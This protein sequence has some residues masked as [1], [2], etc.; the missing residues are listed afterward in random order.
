MKSDEV[1]RDRPEIDAQQI[2]ETRKLHCV[3]NT[4]EP[5]LIKFRKLSCYCAQCLQGFSEDCLKSVYVPPYQ[6]KKI[7]LVKSKADTGNS[8]EKEN[9]E[10][11]KK[12]TEET[13]KST[14][15]AKRNTEGAKKNTEGAKGNTEETKKSK[16]VKKREP[17]I[18]TENE[19]NR[20]RPLVFTSLYGEEENQIQKQISGEEVYSS[21]IACKSYKDLEMFAGQVQ[22]SPI[23]ENPPEVTLL[24]HKRTVD[25]ASLSILP[26]DDDLTNLFPCLIY[27]DDKS[28]QVWKPLRIWNGR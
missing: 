17:L 25:K 7:T 18:S 8:A 3:E 22:L 20:D 14:E 5:Y 6:E 27:G 21:V 24:T 16:A 12:P 10:A 9:R 1:P 26:N 13:K 11:R 19:R 4:K 15:G 2:K 28:S 23:S